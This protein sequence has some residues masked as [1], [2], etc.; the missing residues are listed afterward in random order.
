MG[1]SW[2]SIMMVDSE[3]EKEEKVDA[4][5]KTM[6]KEIEPLLADAKPFFGVSYADTPFPLHTPHYNYPVCRRLL[7]FLG[8]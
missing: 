2:F 5:V 8:V 3:A 7:I 4:W 1:G 6:E